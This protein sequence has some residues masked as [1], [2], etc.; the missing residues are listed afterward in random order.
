VR[1]DAA[2]ASA[3]TGYRGRHVIRPDVPGRRCGAGH[4]GALSCLRRPC[5]LLLRFFAGLT[6]TE[7]GQ[8]VGV[9]QMHVTRLLSR[10]LATLHRQLAD[11]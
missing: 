10:T 3:L 11:D 5:A 6:Q 1:G 4:Q 7:I 9:S 8:R 2:A